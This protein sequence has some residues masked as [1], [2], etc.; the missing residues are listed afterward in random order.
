MGGEKAVS[1][2]DA[3]ILGADDGQAAAQKKYIQWLRERRLKNTEKAEETISQAER[4]IRAQ[5]GDWYNK[6]D[7][8]DLRFLIRQATYLER[9][10]TLEAE[11][12]DAL[13]ER[14]QNYLDPVLSEEERKRH[15]NYLRWC[16]CNPN[17]RLEYDCIQR[18][19]ETIAVEIK[20]S[21]AVREALIQTA[22]TWDGVND[23][24]RLERELTWKSDRETQLKKQLES[25]R[26]SR[27]KLSRIAYNCQKAADRRIYNKAYLAK[28]EHFRTLWYE[29]LQAEQAIMQKLKEVRQQ[30]HD[31]EKAVGTAD[32]KRA[33]RGR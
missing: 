24:S 32:G 11:K 33:E 19:R 12:L 25:I 21:C 14:W 5:L 26:A 15:G 3:A 8:S 28:A 17:S 20:H 9:D 30:R 27:K 29:K 1:A 6:Q 31:A 18:E 10:L 23:L 4:L 13:W 22:K 2:Q 16:G 7:F